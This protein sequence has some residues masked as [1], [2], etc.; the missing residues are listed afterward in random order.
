MKTLIKM[1]VLA[2]A[3]STGAHAHLPK[4]HIV[5]SSNHVINVSQQDMVNWTSKSYMITDNKGGMYTFSGDKT[6]T[7]A[8]SHTKNKVPCIQ[9][10]FFSDPTVTPDFK[11]ELPSSECFIKK[12]SNVYDAAVAHSVNKKKRPRYRNRNQCF[13][14]CKV[15]HHRRNCWIQCP[16]GWTVTTRQK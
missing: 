10:N 2:L 13:Q 11:K 16:L 14:V 5:D 4:S 3:I 9:S 7:N 12:I 1:S 15:K 6:V 8:F